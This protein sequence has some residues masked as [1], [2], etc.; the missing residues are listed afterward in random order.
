MSRDAL[1]IFKASVVATARK[2]AATHTA[3]QKFGDRIPIPAPEFTSIGEP[4]FREQ[5]RETWVA[6]ARLIA[7][8]RMWEWLLKYAR[9][10]VRLSAADCEYLQRE[11]PELPD[12]RPFM[13]HFAK[14]RPDNRSTCEA[15]T[16]LNRLKRMIE[17]QAAVLA[18]HRIPKDLQRR[19][20]RMTGLEMPA[21][22]GVTQ[23]E[24]IDRSVR[25]APEAPPRRLFQLLWSLA[26]FLQRMQTAPASVLRPVRLKPAL[27]MSANVS[28]GTVT[29][30]GQS[31]VSVGE[32]GAAFVRALVHA[33]GDWL[34]GPAM[35]AAEPRLGERTDRTYGALPSEIRK[36][37]Q[38]KPG[39]GYRALSK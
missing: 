19:L 32:E 20:D 22:L 2:W 30:D 7:A 1:R 18:T 16:F 11:F 13:D 31:P 17:D 12:S 23:Q 35:R 15:G 26:R 37:I 33:N 4:I 38:S 34:S 25:P 27:G 8:I 6:A 3:Q 21:L 14:S 36:R 24:V 9:V 29:L 5:L 28:A 39:T 10:R